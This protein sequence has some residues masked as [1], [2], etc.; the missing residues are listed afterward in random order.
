MA[1]LAVCQHCERIRRVPQARGRSKVVPR[2]VVNASCSLSAILLS[3]ILTLQ[4]FELDPQGV[5]FQHRHFQTP[6]NS[7]G[8]PP[9][10]TTEQSELVMGYIEDCLAQLQA[11]TC[12]DVLSFVF[13]NLEPDVLPD[14]LGH[15]INRKTSFK[16][17]SHPIEKKRTE[18]TVA[19]IFEYFEA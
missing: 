16:T 11:P 12:N 19:Q 8:R 14:S 3:A 1:T 18:V 15:W 5:R 9:L 2:S 17:T 6:A 10:F 4:L 7:P 13:E